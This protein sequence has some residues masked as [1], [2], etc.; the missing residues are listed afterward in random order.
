MLIKYSKVRV[1]FLYVIINCCSTFTYA[2]SKVKEQEVFSHVPLVQNTEPFPI[3]TE[4]GKPQLLFQSR[5]SK[6]IN[7]ICKQNEKDISYFPVYPHIFYIPCPKRVLTAKNDQNEIKWAIDLSDYN[8]GQIGYSK[9]GI[10][11]H[12]FDKWKLDIIDLETGH[13]IASFP[14]KSLE[15]KEYPYSALYTKND[16]SLY[17]FCQEGVLKKADLRSQEVL[18]VFKTPKQFFTT[19]ASSLNNMKIDSSGRFF[20][21]SETMGS[22]LNSWGGFGVYDLIDKKVIFSKKVYETS[23][24]VNIA[25]G[26]RQDFFVQYLC[27]EDKKYNICSE[28]YTIQIK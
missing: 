15:C 2:A 11:L 27:Y 28:Y 12:S 4:D 18:T 24:D 7:M 8:G 20:I 6:D 16:H 5:S 26:P 9:D 13:I 3:F 1:V 17:V 21:Y 10:V 22:R 19:I 23:W 14:T 25:V